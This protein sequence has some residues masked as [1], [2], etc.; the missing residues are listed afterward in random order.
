MIYLSLLAKLY[1]GCLMKYCP[2]CGNGNKFCGNC[3]QV[4]VH[5]GK[6]PIDQDGNIKK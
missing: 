6:E 1:G 5:K 4:F 3:G 2:N